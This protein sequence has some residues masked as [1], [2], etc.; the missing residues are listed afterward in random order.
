LRDYWLRLYTEKDVKELEEMGKDDSVHS[1]VDI[2]HIHSAYDEEA[3]MKLALQASSEEAHAISSSSPV[4][5]ESVLPSIRNRYEDGV[6]DD[7]GKAHDTYDE[8][9]RKCSAG[10]VEQEK[11]TSYHSDSS[12]DPPIRT[13][14]LFD[15]DKFQSEDT[16]ETA[17][18]HPAIS[19]HDSDISPLTHDDII[20]VGDSDDGDD[21]VTRGG[22][23]RGNYVVEVNGSTP[24][25]PS[26]WHGATQL[27]FSKPLS[28]MAKGTNSPADTFVRKDVTI[29]SLL[30]GRV[31]TD[32]SQF[33]CLPDEDR[34]QRT[35]KKNGYESSFTDSDK[36]IEID[37]APTAQSSS[38][39]IEIVDDEDDENHAL[40]ENSHKRKPVDVEQYSQ[41]KKRNKH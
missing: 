36:V 17:L 4:N 34:L 1:D 9:K 22:E 3:A 37:A 27:N 38:S 2:H 16:Q 41:K 23:N 30:S 19:E 29:G 32:F 6:F 10:V 40:K 14:D 33:S 21:D 31:P 11:E 15:A 26:E 35:S 5:S 28:R 12:D 25:S 7:L 8:I 13:T 39:F 18:Q 20:N 24:S